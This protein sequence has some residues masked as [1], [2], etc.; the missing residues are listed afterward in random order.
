ML[1]SST[2]DVLCPTPLLWE[3]E[4]RVYLV[5]TRETAR[6]LC[7]V[8]K[9]K[10]RGPSQCERLRFVDVV[11]AAAIRFRE[12]S[13]SKAT[14]LSEDLWT[15]KESNSLGYEKSKWTNMREHTHAHKRQRRRQRRTSVIRISQM[16]LLKLVWKTVDDNKRRDCFGTQ[17]KRGRQKARER[18]WNV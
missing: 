18:M 12:I 11:T 4:H 6:T 9:C 17:A 16:E 2:F 3:T 15:S 10:H 8:S 1:S 5:K 7:V 13:L 14:L